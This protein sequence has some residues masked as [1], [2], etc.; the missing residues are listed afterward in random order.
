MS[1]DEPQRPG[2]EIAGDG[3]L[4]RGD[5]DTK[6]RDRADERFVCTAG[7][8]PSGESPLVESAHTGCLCVTTRRG[9]QSE[10]E[11]IM[12]CEQT[13]NLLLKIVNSGKVTR[14]GPQAS[15]GP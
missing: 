9:P 3:V 7:G 13:T 12:R 6:R 4:K 1:N 14:D 15:E 8:A 11:A 10:A 5:A 2:C